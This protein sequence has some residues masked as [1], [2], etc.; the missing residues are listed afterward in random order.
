MYKM[1]NAF[2]LYNPKFKT[3]KPAVE[4]LSKSQHKQSSINANH[5]KTSQ[6]EELGAVI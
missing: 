5:H 1:Y 3:I 2:L 6:G 4:K